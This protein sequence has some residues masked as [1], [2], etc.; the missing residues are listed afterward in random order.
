MCIFCHFAVSVNVAKCLLNIV[1]IFYYIYVLRNVC[2]EYKHRILNENIASFATIKN[3]FTTY[4]SQPIGDV[5]ISAGNV[6]DS[7]NLIDRR[8]GSAYHP[9][10]IFLHDVIVR[11]SSILAG[12]E[13]RGGLNI[14]SGKAISQRSWGN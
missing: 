4:I 8:S 13:G 11:L 9:S 14:F 12:Y 6:I 5:T 7:G 1:F 10:N 2:S 3:S